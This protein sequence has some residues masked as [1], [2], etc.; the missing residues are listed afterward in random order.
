MP[1]AGASDQQRRRGSPTH[2]D[3]VV[4]SM[5]PGPDVMTGEPAG[6]A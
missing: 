5:S 3:K 2:A 1:R 6:T 4:K